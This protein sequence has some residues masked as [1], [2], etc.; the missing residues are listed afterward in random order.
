MPIFLFYRIKKNALNK[1]MRSFKVINKQ[2]I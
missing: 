1:L 2:K